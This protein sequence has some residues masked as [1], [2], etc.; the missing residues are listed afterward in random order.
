MIDGAPDIH[1]VNMLN[2][3]AVTM[4]ITISMNMMIMTVE[5]IDVVSII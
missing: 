2:T 4:T 1:I 3:Y 5:S